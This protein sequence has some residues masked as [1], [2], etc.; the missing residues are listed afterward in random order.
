[1]QSL[2]LQEYVNNDAARAI[3]TFLTR[4]TVGLLIFLGEGSNGKTTLIRDIKELYPDIYVI[5][6]HTDNDSDIIA[7]SQTRRVIYE[8]NEMPNMAVRVMGTII[9]FLYKL[10]SMP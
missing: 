1:M 4:K 2:R 8:V 6:D 9:H 3:T 10:T 7:L 5:D